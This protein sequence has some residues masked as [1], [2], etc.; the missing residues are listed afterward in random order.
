MRDRFVVIFNENDL[1]HALIGS[2]T[3]ITVEKQAE[4]T[5]QTYAHIV[6]ASSEYLALIDL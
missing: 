1:P 4:N 2:L 6:S 3:D 5:L